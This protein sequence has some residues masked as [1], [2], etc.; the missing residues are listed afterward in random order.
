[1]FFMGRRAARGRRGKS[2]ILAGLGIFVIGLVI[3]GPDPAQEVPGAGT[4]QPAYD[5][6]GYGLPRN[7]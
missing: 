5:Q 4:D 1:M 6:P 3:P 2:L 7:T